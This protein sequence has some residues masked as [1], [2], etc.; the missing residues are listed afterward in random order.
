MVF[1]RGLRNKA[2]APVASGPLTP[3]FNRCGNMTSWGANN[4][5]PI[6]FEHEGGEDVLD[7]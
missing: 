1:P 6:T 3:T 7:G 2:V 5:R 4:S